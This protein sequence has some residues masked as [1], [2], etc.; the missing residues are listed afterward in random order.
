LADETGGPDKEDSENKAEDQTGGLDPDDPSAVKDVIDYTEEILSEE[1][2]QKLL[3]RLRDL[4]G[5]LSEY[6]KST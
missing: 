4:L 1:D 6:D 2:A 5:T 3:S